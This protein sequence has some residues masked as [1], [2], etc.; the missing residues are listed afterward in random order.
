MLVVYFNCYFLYKKRCRSTLISVDH[1][2]CDNI[3]R[4]MKF[5]WTFIVLIAV[6]SVLAAEDTPGFF[7]KVTR[8]IPRVRQTL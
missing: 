7:L 4:A 1:L 3:F 8:N 5:T 2:F 6:G